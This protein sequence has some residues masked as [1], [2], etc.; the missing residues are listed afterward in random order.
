MVCS[1][2][3]TRLNF[4]STTPSNWPVMTRNGYRLD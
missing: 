3:A 4:L 1:H 2:L